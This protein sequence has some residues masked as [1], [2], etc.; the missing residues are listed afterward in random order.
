MAATRGFSGAEVVA[1]CTE[2][3]LASMEESEDNSAVA[4]RHLL[5]AAKNVKP[6]ITSQMISFYESFA[7]GSL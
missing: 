1:V 7:N 4:L 2:A 6:Q 3:A 5:D